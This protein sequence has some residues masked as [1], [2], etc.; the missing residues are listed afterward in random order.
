MHHVL[1]REQ[2][3]PR[4]RAEVFAFFSHAENLEAITPS[5]LRFRIVTPLPIA[6]QE[7][8][9]IDYRLRLLGIPMRWRSRIDVWEPGVRFVDRQLVGPYARWVHFHE[10]DDVPGGV[11][12]RDR[13]EYTLP[14]APISDLVHP[15]LRLQLDAIFAFRRRTIESA[16]LS[17]NRR[18]L[19]FR[20]T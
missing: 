7:G 8:T 3:L 15:I 2:L 20:E 4:S 10:F 13:V 12:M 5:W 16:F 18:P 6:M 1:E 19:R 14:G 17:T 9:V 11:R